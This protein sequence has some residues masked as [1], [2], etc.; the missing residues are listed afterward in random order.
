MNYA[1]E[2]TGI[3][4]RFGAV[5]ALDSVDL[6]VKAGAIHALVGENGA[7]KTTLMKILY[8]AL[9]PDSGQLSVKGSS[10]EFR[11]S[12]QAIAAGVG[13]VSQHYGIIPEL[14][15]LQNLMLGAEDGPIIRS[16]EARQRAEELARSMGFRFD[17]NADASLLSPA[18]AQKL[19]I[20]KLLWRKA[21]IM[22]L[23]EPTAM[24]S[25]ADGDALFHSLRKLTEDGA[26]VILVTHRLPEVFDHCSQVTVLRG[27]KRVAEKAVFETSKNELAELIVG[28]ALESNEVRNPELGSTRLQITRLQVFNDRGAEAL[29][30]INLEVK[31]GEIVGIAGVDGSGQRELVQSLVGT[32]PIS[33]GTITFDDLPISS[34]S[35]AMRIAA[36]LRLIP[37]DRHEDGVIEEWSL[38]ENAALG[39]QRLFPFSKK[40]KI[41][42]RRRA[43]EA[44]KIAQR[45]STKHGGL[46]QPMSSL[47][48][49]NQQ[50]FVAARALDIEPK[51]IVAF[52]PARGLDLAATAE[53]YRGIRDACSAG[54]C[55]LVVSFDL[56]ELLENCD[57]VVAMNR[58]EVFEPPP[59]KELDRDAIGRLM[60]GAQ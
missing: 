30:S 52:Q 39:L 20:L 32:R 8:G 59:N 4:K 15:C 12:A 33:Q 43:E 1:V 36:G 38:E 55:A 14:S 34:E 22:I 3:S 57:R 25:P 6:H 7:G 35:P 16:E 49:G 31:S 18:A 47:S 2:M 48:G 54:A 44:A 28:K 45:F 60:V 29:K 51:L 46:A 5:Q 56:D 40:G 41:D 13:M 23:D 27:G 9:H 17:W 24:L 19:E 11:S 26:T 50:R 10:T 58:G 21:E 37:E 42:I 53:V